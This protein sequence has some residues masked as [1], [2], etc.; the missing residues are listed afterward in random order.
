[1]T[2]EERY[3]EYDERIDRYLR[4]QMDDSERT[5]FEQDVD[6]DQELRER[7]LATAMLVKGISQTGMQ[8]E[9]QAQLD[10]IKQMSKD[11]FVQATRGKMG[12]NPF[13]S[14][15]KWASGI[16]AAAFVAYGLYIFY[17]SHTTRQTKQ[18][19][20][21]EEAPVKT[22][23]TPKPTKP[24]L[25]NLADEYNKPFGNE[26]NEFV[27]IRQQI[28][29][30]AS[31]DMMAVVYDVDKVEWPTANHGPKGADDEEEVKNTTDNFNDCS[32][33]Y[34][35]LA[36]LKKGDKE[37]AINELDELIEKGHNEILIERATELL[38]KL[39]E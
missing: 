8:Q 22:K 14:F 27:S 24:S 31:K 30:G 26:P 28:K 34:K 36:Y 12:N 3:I 4:N 1:M 19:A 32:L 20:K 18:T 11:E 17:P 37:S 16:A 23:V 10:A 33:W 13:M 38:K 39:K 35:A 21:V 6:N 29:N 2:R 5:A 7:L 15:M 25:A 9:G